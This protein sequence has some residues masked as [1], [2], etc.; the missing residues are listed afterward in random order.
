MPTMPMGFIPLTLGTVAEKL[1]YAF[2]S[3]LLEDVLTVLTI[4]RDT[5]SYAAPSMAL[6]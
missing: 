4:E 3:T 6:A 5:E 1:A 2:C